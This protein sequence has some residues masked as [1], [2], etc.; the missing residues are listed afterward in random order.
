[1]FGFF[2]WLRGKIGLILSFFLDRDKRRKLLFLFVVHGCVK[3][4]KDEVG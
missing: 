3:I 1:M 4:W 2:L